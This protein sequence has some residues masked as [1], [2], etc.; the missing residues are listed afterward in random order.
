M[1]QQKTI[2]ILGSTSVGKSALTL[3]YIRDEFPDYYA[4]T[5]M[6]RMCLF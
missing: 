5:I 3:R 4:P 2:V 6:N 1:S